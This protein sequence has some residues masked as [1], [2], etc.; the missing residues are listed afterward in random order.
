VQ[1]QTNLFQQS[2]AQFCVQAECDNKTEKIFLATKRLPIF[3]QPISCFKI[4][5]MRRDVF[6]AIADPTR[7]EIINLLAQQRLNLNTVTASF[8]ISRQAISKHIKILT[9]C[10]L[11][12]IQTQGRERYCE[13]QLQKLAEVSNWIDQYKKLWNKRL[14]TLESYLDHLQTKNKKY[15]KG[16]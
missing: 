4:I 16:K 10:G 14:D 6:Q 2:F 1:A 3:V 15:D 12:T 7:R 9:E 13:V 5:N 8:D 11:I